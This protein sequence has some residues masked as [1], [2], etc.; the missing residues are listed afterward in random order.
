MIA[1]LRLVRA[2]AHLPTLLAAAVLF[3]LMLMTFADVVLRSAVSAPIE[4]AT[5]L[6]RIAMAVIVFSVL[7]VVSG[8]GDHIT[9]DLTDPWFGPAATRWRECIVSLACGAMLFWPA[10]AV[11]RLAER[12]RGYGDVTEYLGIPDFYTGWFIA[13]CVYLAAIVLVAR[14]LILAVAPALLSDREPPA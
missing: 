12:A 5:E 1:L 6:T 4:A 7:P 2:A 14:G 10:G 9:V 8:R 13:A 3:G 11:L